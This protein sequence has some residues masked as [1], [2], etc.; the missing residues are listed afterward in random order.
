M[1]ATIIYLNGQNQCM[2]ET[3]SVFLFQTNKNNYDLIH[4]SSWQAVIYHPKVKCILRYFGTNKLYTIDY[5]ILGVSYFL[6]KYYAPDM[7][8]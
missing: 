2:E 8:I 1:N 4:T 3:G 5:Y 7:V 6:N